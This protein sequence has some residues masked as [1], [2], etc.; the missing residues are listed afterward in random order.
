MK[1]YHNPAA[2]TNVFFFL[3]LISFSNYISQKPNN[4][5]FGLK[6]T[7]K[8]CKNELKIKTIE[9]EQ[10]KKHVKYSKIKEMEV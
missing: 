8:E 10:I 6:N 2:E 7:I 1:S 3:N 9:L 4:L 5:Q